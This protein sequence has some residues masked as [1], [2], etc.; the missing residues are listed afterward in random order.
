VLCNPH[1]LTVVFHQ[2]GE[3]IVRRYQLACARGLAHAIVMP[4]VTEDLLDR[5]VADWTEWMQSDRGP[6]PR[7]LA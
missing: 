5:F 7:S 1:S 2:P 4:N 3:Q 6:Q